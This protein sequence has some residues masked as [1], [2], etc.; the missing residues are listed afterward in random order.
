VSAGDHQAQT[1]HKMTI[2]AIF[3]K[4]EGI[5]HHTDKLSISFWTLNN[6]WH[7]KLGISKR[8][9]SC[10]SKNASVMVF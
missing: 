6:T 7:A 2:I 4:K 3:F 5:E 10:T 1:K 9:K 8:T